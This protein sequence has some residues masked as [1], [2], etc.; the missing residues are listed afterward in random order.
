MVQFIFS[1]S[2]WLLGVRFKVIKKATILDIIINPYHQQFV[3]VFNLITNTN[4]SSRHFYKNK[5]HMT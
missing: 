4:P 1:K 3:S 5:M 2:W